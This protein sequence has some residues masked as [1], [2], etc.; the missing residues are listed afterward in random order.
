MSEKSGFRIHLLITDAKRKKVIV[1]KENGKIEL[2]SV[3]YKTEGWFWSAALLNEIAE[4]A[5]TETGI[6]QH[7]LREISIHKY[8]CLCDMEM[9][10]DLKDMDQKFSYEN[11]SV[12]E[13]IALESDI[14]KEKLMDYYRSN[15]PVHPLRPEWEKHG[16][17]K[18]TVSK[19]EKALIK[20]KYTLSGEI[21]KVKS[22]SGGV[23]IAAPVGNEK[24]LF[25][26]MSLSKGLIEPGV[27]NNISKKFPDNVAEIITADFKAGW[28]IMKEFERKYVFEIEDIKIQKKKAAEI[29]KA[30]ADI[31]IEFSE[32]IEK[33]KKQ[34][35][36]FL[37][38]IKI[39]E[40]FK[41]LL[42]DKNALKSGRDPISDDDIKLMKSFLPELKLKCEKLSEYNVPYSIVHE[43]FRSDHIALDGKKTIFYDWADTILAHPFFSVNRYIDFMGIPDCSER[44]DHEFND[45]EDDYRRLVRDSYLKQFRIFETPKRLKE[46]FILSRD[47][48]YFYLALRWYRYSFLYETSDLE[49]GSVRDE[50]RRIAG[51]IKH[52]KGYRIESVK[53]DDCQLQKFCG[54]FWCERTNL[55]RK[56]YLKN[57][58]LFYLRNDESRSGL[59]PISETQLKMVT[60][61]DNS[62]DFELVN[63]KWQFTFEVK[64]EEPSSSLFVPKKENAEIEKETAK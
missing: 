28:M 12:L 37:P 57:G 13:D 41:K 43:D 19:I 17:F 60:D 58:K 21:R 32:D 8:D 35:A 59:V 7:F 29:I 38:N 48:N 63:G 31:Q 9:L 61:V 56:I 51:F 25:Y 53:L 22:F 44:F 2:P 4:L 52:L 47:L 27:I 18:K 15:F 42:K 20:N 34:N 3:I 40:E 54:E 46:A 33:W 16:W 49:L 36:V 26:K 30:F 23:I 45:P 50:L 5:K 64:G 11:I 10:S 39:Y 55:S 1:K 62:L 24:N 14:V 6:L